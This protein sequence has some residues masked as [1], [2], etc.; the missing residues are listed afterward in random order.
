MG[1]IDKQQFLLDLSARLGDFVPANDVHR[2]LA[3]ADEAL[4]GYEMTTLPP[5]GD[6]DSKDL[7]K[8]F[9]DAKR[10][11]GRSEKTV[12]RYEYIL[13]RL[14][15]DTGIPFRRMTVYHIRNY[16][17]A[18]RERGI[19][20][21]TIEGYRQTYSSFFGWLQREGLL[22]GNP[23]NNLTAVKTPKV[24]RKPF[25]SVELAK[26]NEAAE[27]NRDRTLL[28]FL[29]STG[30][31]IS[32]VCSV[33]RDDVNFQSLSLKVHGKG[34]KERIVFI[35]DVTAMHLKRYLD[36]RTDSSPAL[37]TG[38]GTDRL[39]PGGVQRILKKLGQAS[40]VENVH[41]HRF[42]RTLATSLIDS[43]MPIQEVATILGHDKIDTTMTYVYIDVKNVANAYR[44]FAACR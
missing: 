34:D 32:E 38:K 40:G 20:S 44:R 35:D 6:D 33:N 18:E 3:E 13:N 5:G 22:D 17:T 25:S 27:T 15:K 43:G 12:A 26:L 30:C 31:R 28:S 39:Q 16:Y 23:M 14:L 9:L 37:F 42:R 8:Y 36:E 11:E 24:V 10:V 41:P 4:Q 21:R 2:I 19:S 1:L 7:L 29:R